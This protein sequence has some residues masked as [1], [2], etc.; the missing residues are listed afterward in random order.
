MNKEVKT[1]ETRAEKIFYA[2]VM[3]LGAIAIMVI[4]LINI[5]W[6]GDSGKI[7]KKYE[8]LNKGEHVFVSIKED[9]LKKKIEN[10]ESFQLFVGNEDLNDVDYFVYYA[11]E[12]A[13]EYK[14]SEIY[15]FDTKKIT[16]EMVLY[17]RQNSI[18]ELSI[19]VPNLIFYENGK[20]SRI[21]GAEDF[22]KYYGSNYYLLLKNY[23][24]NC[25]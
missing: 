4:V 2:I 1:Q 11:N 25:Y 24:E 13:K 8:Y 19:E 10:G 22:D 20:A 3:A 21:S 5:P 7:A 15:Y 18:D 9:E 23:F 6:G 14:V 17:L 16:D 12:L